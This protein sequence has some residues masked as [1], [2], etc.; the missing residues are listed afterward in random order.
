MTDSEDLLLSSYDYS[1][2]SKYIA[3]V[4]ADPRHSAK[5][6]IVGDKNKGLNSFRHSKILDWIDELNQGDLVI[7]NNTKVVKARLRVRMENGSLG[8]LLLL[9][10]SDSYGKWRCLAKPAKKMRLGDNLILEG[11]GERSLSLKVVG[12]DNSSGGR[13]LLFPSEFFNWESIETLLEKYGEVPLPPYIDRCNPNDQDR[14]QTRYALRPGAVAAPTAGLHLSDYLLES[15]EKKGVILKQVTLHV[16]LGT[17]RPIQ[18]EDLSELKLHSEWIEVSE[19][20]V[21]AVEDCRKR[22]GRVIAVG[23]T[24]VRALEGAFSK[25]E[26]K[27]KPKSG[28]IDLVIKPGYRF[29][30][31]DGLL[32][33]FH[34][35]RSSLLLLVSAFIGRKKLLAL[36]KKAIESKYRFFSYGDAM[37]IPPESVLS[38]SRSDF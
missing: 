31:V 16:G 5:L 30:V 14:Y 32:T 26:R 2:D 28:Q 10:P 19:E 35:P 1:L 36:Y 29:G 15:L 20:V 4:P 25:T 11:L 17:F 3:Q 18:I 23:T 24:T 12:I 9:Q 8:E 21:E 34:L 38:E 27:L 22:N 13:L 37:W 6:M 33:N 7:V